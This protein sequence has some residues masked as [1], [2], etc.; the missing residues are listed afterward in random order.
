MEKLT[1]CARFVHLN[2]QPISFAGRPYLPA[3][4]ASAGR[5]LVLRCSRQTEKST[6]LANTILYEACMHAGME[7]LLVCPRMEQARVFVRSRL[8][9]ALLESPII[10]RNLLGRTGRSPQI[11]NMRFANGSRL[12]VRAAYRSAD[13]CRGLSASLLLVDEFQDIA[14]DDLP[15]LQETLSHAAHGRTILTVRPS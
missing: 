1:F 9:P 14:A 6:F 5:N 3:I 11:T 2:R 10:R 13:A 7:I 8:L 15:V 12:F 4:Y